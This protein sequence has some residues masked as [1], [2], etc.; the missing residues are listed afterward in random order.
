MEADW[1]CNRA[2][3][4]GEHC[5]FDGRGHL[6]RN[7]SWHISGQGGLW[8]KFNLAKGASPWAFA[9]DPARV[10]AFYNIRWANCVASEGLS[11]LRRDL[12]DNANL[13]KRSRKIGR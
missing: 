6:D 12:R 10:Q 4:H 7:W 1:P 13:P 5:D 8:S 2:G 9:N 3:D 11:G